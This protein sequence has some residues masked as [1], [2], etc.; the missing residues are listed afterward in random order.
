M[1]TFEAFAEIDAYQRRPD[2][3]TQYLIGLVVV[4]MIYLETSTW[5]GASQIYTYG[6]DKGVAA[7]FQFNLDIT[8]MEKC[9]DIGVMIYDGANDRLLVNELVNIVP[10]PTFNAIDDTN[11]GEDWCRISG[12]FRSNRVAGRLSIGPRKPSF[13]GQATAFNASHYVHE[14]SFGPYYPSQLNPLDDAMKVSQEKEHVL[15]YFLSVVPTTYKA[16]GMTVETNQYTVTEVEKQPP[17]GTVT[18]LHFLYD[19]EAISVTIH[20]DRIGFFDW[21]ARVANILGGLKVCSSIMGLN[22]K[23]AADAKGLLD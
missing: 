11:G 14:L 1:R 20:D 17:P 23:K 3:L 9:D 12:I 5:L 6:V 22:A 2:R 21:L 7:D 16:L 10:V 8:M 4:F 19:F 15:A 13:W 18:G